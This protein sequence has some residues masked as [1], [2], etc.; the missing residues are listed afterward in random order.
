MQQIDDL[1]YY[2]SNNVNDNENDDDIFHNT[3]LVE[4]MIAETNKDDDNVNGEPL[5]N[6]FRHSAYQKQQRNIFN[7]NMRFNIC[8]TLSV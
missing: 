8:P 6:E 3:I 1:V 5:N 2:D 7:L 4:D